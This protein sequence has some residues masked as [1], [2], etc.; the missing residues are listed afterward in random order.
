MRVPIVLPFAQS[1]EVMT[2]TGAVT[3]TL[4]EH[5]LKPVFRAK[6][7]VPAPEAVPVIV[8]VNESFP[9]IKLPAAKVAV[10]PVTPVEF[11]T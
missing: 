6:F 8:Y 3:G 5:D 4:T 11:T 9:E 10:N 1:K 7:A 2:P